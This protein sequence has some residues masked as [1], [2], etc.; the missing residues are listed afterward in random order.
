MTQKSTNEGINNVTTAI[1]LVPL[2]LY[3]T[4]IIINVIISL[5]HATFPKK[6]QEQSNDVRGTWFKHDQ[7]NEQEL[8]KDNISGVVRRQLMATPT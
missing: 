2:L 8:I 4:T 7:D 1:L 6:L 5:I 3:V